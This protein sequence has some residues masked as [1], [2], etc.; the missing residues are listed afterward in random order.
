MTTDSPELPDDDE[1]TV[2]VQRGAKASSDSDSDS[3][4]ERT[5]MVQRGA[6]AS[7]DSDSDSDDERTVMVQRGTKAS[8]DS[9]SDQTI[10]VKRARPATADAKG[11]RPQPGRRRGIS[12]PPVPDGFGPR[13]VEAAGPGAIETYAV[14]PLPSPAPEAVALEDG[15]QAT[16]IS[17][18]AMPSVSKRGRR[19]ARVA[20]TA[21]AASWVV[22][23]VGIAAIVVFVLL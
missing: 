5:V 13:A 4:N 8:S 16:R 18:P 17:A 9:D 23:V 14:R 3:D 2:M 22:A 6:K 21:Y 1:R 12:P 7:S 19:A 15:R 10:A 20:L 11:D